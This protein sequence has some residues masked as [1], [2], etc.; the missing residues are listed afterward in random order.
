MVAEIRGDHGAEWAA[1]GQV[2]DLLEVGSAETV[3]KWCRQAEVDRGS[4][5]GVSSEA[6]K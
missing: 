6:A 1:M 3:R 5:P 2:A 4:R